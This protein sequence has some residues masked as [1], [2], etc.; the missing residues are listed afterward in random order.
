MVKRHTTL[1]I[2]DDLLVEAKEKGI[3]IS[4]ITKEAIMLKL[5]KQEVVVDLSIEA[6]EFCGKKEEKGEHANSYK[7]LTWLYPD[8]KW[9]CNNCLL[10]EGRKI[11]ASLA[12]R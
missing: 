10:K 6:C 9:I 5:K 12:F 8:E 4:E 11:P 1:N 7:G 2:E 3:N